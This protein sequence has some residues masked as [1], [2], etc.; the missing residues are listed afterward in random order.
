[1]DTKKNYPQE[2]QGNSSKRKYEVKNFEKCSDGS[3]RPKRV[4]LDKSKKISMK[5]KKEISN[6]KSHKC[7]F[8]T[9]NVHKQQSEEF[10]DEGNVDKQSIIQSESE[11]PS[12]IEDSTTNKLHAIS[13]PGPSQRIVK[14]ISDQNCGVQSG[15]ETPSLIDGIDPDKSVYQPENINR[16]DTVGLVEHSEMV[17]SSQGSK[18]SFSQSTIAEFLAAECDE[19]VVPELSSFS[20]SS[21]HSLP[22]EE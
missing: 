8:N 16:K 4:K 9:T 17:E 13:L 3:K 2:K 10:N 1:M 18:H 12:F 20:Q 11:T 21:H 19:A 6:E 15:S 14:D 5:N 22:F 7:I